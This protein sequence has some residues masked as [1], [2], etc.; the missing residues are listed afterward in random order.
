MDTYI[1]YYADH[2]EV[3]QDGGLNQVCLTIENTYDIFIAE[4]LELV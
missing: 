2:I 4:N 1:E 3:Y